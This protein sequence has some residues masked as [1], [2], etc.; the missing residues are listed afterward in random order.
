MKL[1]IRG[2]RVKA[3][4]ITGALVAAALPLAAAS[5]AGAANTPGNTCAGVFSGGLSATEDVLPDGIIPLTNG[6]INVAPVL[7]GAD[8]IVNDVSNNV[9]K[10]TRFAAN[11][12]LGAS[13][14]FDQLLATPNVGTGTLKVTWKNGAVKTPKVGDNA[15]PNN[16]VDPEYKLPTIEVSESQKLTL[17]APKKIILNKGVATGVPAITGVSIGN[18]PPAALIQTIG[19]GPVS[20]DDI[21]AA[22]FVVSY[23]ATYFPTLQAIATIY[24]YDA[25]DLST[26]NAGPASFVVQGN[27]AL[28]ALN[29]LYVPVDPADGPQTACTTLGLIMVACQN[30]PG[31]LPGT[32]SG[33]CLTLV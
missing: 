7:K 1:S 22:T 13:P 26:Q 16:G 32:V 12:Q 24:P 5:S 8:K 31:L 25:A 28:G 23:K 33:L 4:A 30:A 17:L 27:A 3:L 10:G 11:L 21:I 2:K 9:A 29:P 20:G 15:D 18:T 19:A 6:Y 14:G